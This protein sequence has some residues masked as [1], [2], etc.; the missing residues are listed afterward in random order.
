M[1]RY[2][3]LSAAALLAS[4]NGAIASHAES[5]GISLGNG[6]GIGIVG[7]G[8]IYAA[9]YFGCGS[10]ISN[11]QGL[12]RKTGRRT[13]SVEL[14]D[15]YFGSQTNYGRSF[16][17]SLPIKS[18]GTWALWLE[19]NGTTAF[20]ADSGTYTV[21]AAARRTRGNLAAET[22]ALVARLKAERA[23]R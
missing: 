13:K 17:I 21:G 23:H 16:D 5:A 2:L 22:K 10:G 14:S 20:I 12:S 8:G 19:F 3:M 6:C 7:G 9:Q 18:G 1:N 4:T 15:N 11:G